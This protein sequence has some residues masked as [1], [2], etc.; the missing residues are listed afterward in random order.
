MKRGNHSKSRA[1][2]GLVMLLALV[3]VFGVAVG[4]TIAWLTDKTDTVTNTFTT[5]GIEVT[6]AE[7]EGTGDGLNK[8]YQMIPGHT[9]KKDPTVTVKA[10]SED[11]YVFI[12]VEKTNGVD[13]YLDYSI[14][15]GW[16]ELEKDSGVYYHVFTKT[17][18][19]QP[20][21]ILTNNTVTVKGEVTQAMM[22]TAETSAPTL[23]FTAYACQY[24]NGNANGTLT[25]FEPADAWT[26]AQNAPNSATPNI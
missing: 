6:I 16:T 3:L 4:G 9:I 15:S 17:S 18:S 11:C 12:K 8:S 23:S 25:H 22:K 10:N 21:A 5:S 19:D 14:N 24:Y 13:N 7:T 1:S 26:F 20:L 2:K